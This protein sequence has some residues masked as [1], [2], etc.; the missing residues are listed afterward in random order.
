[1]PYKTH[2]LCI[3]RW[4]AIVCSSSKIHDEFESFFIDQAPWLEIDK[5]IILHVSEGY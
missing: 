5:K 3:V 2:V 1:M 4:S